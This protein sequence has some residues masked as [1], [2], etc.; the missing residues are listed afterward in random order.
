MRRFKHRLLSEDELHAA[1]AAVAVEQ[2]LHAVSL[3]AVADRLQVPLKSALALRPVEADLV[4]A[5][6][7][8]VVAAELA[9]VKRLVLGRPAPRGQLTALLDTLGQP[10]RAE[11]DAVWLEAWGLGRRN[12]ALAAAVRA[13]EGAWHA[14]V[15]AV[16]RRG[17]RAGDFPEVD[18]DA[19]ASRLLVTLTGVNAYA[20]VD[21][22]SHVD[23]AELLRAVARAELGMVFDGVEAVPAC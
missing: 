13:E 9:E 4:S 19:V 20:L 23:R 12:P 5:A 2:G 1:A 21:Y 16:I 15:G 7:T 17:V 10:S 22:R 11:V 8:S 6:Y 3:Q 14:F 18:P